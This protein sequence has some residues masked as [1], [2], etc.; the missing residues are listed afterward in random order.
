MGQ[1]K[2]ILYCCRSLK[3]ATHFCLTTL[4]SSSATWERVEKKGRRRRREGIINL[5]IYQRLSVCP[6]III[7]YSLWGGCCAQWDAVGREKMSGRKP[8]ELQM[9]KSQTCKPASD[10]DDLDSAGITAETK[11][12][13]QEGVI[14]S[15]NWCFLKYIFKITPVVQFKEVNRL[16]W[17]KNKFFSSYGNIREVYAIL[18]ICKSHTNGSSIGKFSD[19]FT[20]C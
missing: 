5:L 15:S 9:L 6:A 14:I 3:K 16:Q 1:W 2:S 17:S 19:P 12:L 8:R 11:Q 10:H 20:C 7:L 18:C 13:Y 4:S